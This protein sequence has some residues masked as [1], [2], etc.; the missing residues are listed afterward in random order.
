M[1]CSRECYVYA[2]IFLGR[3]IQR[4]RYC[5]TMRNIHRLLITSFFFFYIVCFYRFFSVVIAAKFLDDEYYKNTYYA[6]IGGI[7]VL[8]LNSLEIDFLKSIKFNLVI[9]CASYYKIYNQ[10]MKKEHF[11]ELDG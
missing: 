1:L 11:Y 5:L 4:T 10:L 9:D 2:L 3:Y 8:E 6:S 7:P